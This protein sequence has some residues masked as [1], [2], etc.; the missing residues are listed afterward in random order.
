M[1]PVIY[2]SYEGIAAVFRYIL[3]NKNGT[4]I[5][6]VVILLALVMCLC[7]CVLWFIGKTRRGNELVQQQQAASAHLEER[8]LY[9][10]RFESRRLKDKRKVDEM[11]TKLRCKMKK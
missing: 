9:T 7:W 5:V 4:Y 6:L 2:L 8:R 3:K 11:I 1:H 10:S